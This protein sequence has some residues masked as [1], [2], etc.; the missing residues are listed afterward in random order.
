MRPKISIIGPSHRTHLWKPFYESIKTNLDFEV[1]FVTDIEPKPEEIPSKKE[2]YYESVED[3]MKMINFL[4]EFQPI[5]GLERIPI[6]QY[7]IVKATR[8]RADRD[9]F[10]ERK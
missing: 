10:T 4:K 7:E 2:I 5:V 3:A 8:E 6:T 9:D 1:I